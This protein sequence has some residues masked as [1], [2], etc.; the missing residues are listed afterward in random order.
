MSCRADLVAKKCCTMPCI[1]TVLDLAKDLTYDLLI[2]ACVQ[3]DLSSMSSAVAAFNC[4][5]SPLWSSALSYSSLVFYFSVFQLLV[6]VLCPVYH[7]RSHFCLSLT[8]FPSPSFTPP[9]FSLLSLSRATEF[10]EEE[11]EVIAAFT[12]MVAVPLFCLPCF[13]KYSV[14]LLL[15]I[16]IHGTLPFKIP[17][18][19][20]SFYYH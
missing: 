11:T 2:M 20:C 17:F 16:C 5:S 13:F 1:S 12:E 10:L 3:S 6:H 4:A 18:G 8:E 7:S 9:L 15:W 19:L 14:V